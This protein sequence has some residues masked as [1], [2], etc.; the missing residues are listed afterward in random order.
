MKIRCK[1]TKLCIEIPN[2]EP[3]RPYI[4]S[5]KKGIL[6]KWHYVIDS[7]TKCP[8]LYFGD[9]DEVTYEGL[10]DINSLLTRRDKERRFNKKKG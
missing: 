8:K 5:F 1:F 7:E 2:E 9:N 10:C 6:G 4:V 3:I